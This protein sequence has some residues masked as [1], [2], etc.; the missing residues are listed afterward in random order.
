MNEDIWGIKQQDNCLGASSNWNRVYNGSVR[1]GWQKVKY[2][3]DHSTT[4]YHVV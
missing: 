4:V 3:V 1:E 2:M